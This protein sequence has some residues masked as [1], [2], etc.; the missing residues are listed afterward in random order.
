MKTMKTYSRFF[1]LLFLLLWPAVLQAEPSPAPTAPNTQA[2]A[3]DETWFNQQAQIFY[4][5]HIEYIKR[6]QADK[7]NVQQRIE[8]L[9]V[10]K[11]VAENEAAKQK[12]D[13]EIKNLQNKMEELNENSAKHDLDTAEF[14]LISAQHRLEIAK[15]NLAK[16]R[17]ERKK[18]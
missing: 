17:A 8:T 14:G 16:I 12:I 10:N 6:I 9:K 7:K 11:F 15:K 2:K 13:Q 5:N 1:I 3:E 4:K 18:G